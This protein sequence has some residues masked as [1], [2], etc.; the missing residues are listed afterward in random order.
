MTSPSMSGLLTHVLVLMLTLNAWT[1]L[2]HEGLPLDENVAMAEGRQASMD[3]DCTGYSFEDLFE[4]DFA[5]FGLTVLDDW[6]TGEM[7]ATAWVNESN[8]AIVRDNLDGLFE[9]ISDNGYISTDERDAIR[10]IGPSCIADMDTRLTMDE[11]AP[12][13]G[14]GG[15][16]RF[17]FVQEGIG[18]DEVNL[19]PLDHEGVRTCQT[20]GSTSSCKE[21]PTS[22]TDNL[23]IALDVA[24]GETNNVRW[25]QLPNSGASNFTLSMNI[26]NMS[27]AAL[28]VTFPALSGLRL[29]DFRVVD[30][31]PATGDTCDHIADPSFT[32][33]AD[34]RLTITQLVNFDRTL[35]DLECHM[36]MDFTTEAPVNNDAPAWTEA[37]P[38]NGSVIATAGAGT[39]RMAAG[40]TAFTWGEDADGWQLMCEFD[41]PDWTVTANVLGDLFVNQPTTSSVANGTCRLVDPLGAVD[42]N[43]TRTWMFGTLFSAT[44]DV[45]EDGIGGV[46]HLTGTGLVDQATVRLQAVQDQRTGELSDAA[47]LNGGETVNITFSNAGFQPGVFTI[48]LVAEAIGMLPLM[49]TLDL[50]LVKPNSLP[51]LVV[52]PNFYGENATWSENLQRFTLTGTVSDADLEPVSLRLSLCG[53]DYTDFT[54]EGINW[55]IDVST[56][57]CVANTLEVTHVTLTATDDSGGVTELTAIVD[58][59]ISDEPSGVPEPA[60]A[61]DEDSLPFLS[62]H[63]VLAC[64]GAALVLRRADEE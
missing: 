46:A 34:G 42:D 40:A 19:V 61:S 13:D 35:W 11:G 52:Q 18:L 3:V 49:A 36:F 1:G 25:D 17:Q 41:Q 51:V 54:V 12:H 2:A 9:G 53:A 29:V 38:E 7:F 55:A 31:A 37:A 63:L 10:S 4:Y 56:A 27:N 28:V 5:L 24:E 32:Y 8:A 20:F 59:P 62:I 33:L 60:P 22:A 26:T 45:A 15:T 58:A 64:L 16:N 39:T 44:A 6:A 30:N 48:N 47:T 23:E 43:N 57:I 14:E 21:V 50:G